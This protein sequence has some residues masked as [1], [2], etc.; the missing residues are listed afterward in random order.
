MAA[1]NSKLWHL[2]QINLFKD[3]SDEE[4]EELDHLTATSRKTLTTVL[5]DLKEKDLLYMERKRF[6]IRELDKLV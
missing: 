5:N 6:L 3:L 2:E 1:Q 4:L